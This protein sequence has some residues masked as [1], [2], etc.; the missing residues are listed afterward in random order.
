MAESEE[1]NT[2]S[3]TASAKIGVYRHWMVTLRDIQWEL[4]ALEYD[5]EYQRYE[6]DVTRRLHDA[7]EDEKE[8]KHWQKQIARISKAMANTEAELAK[9]Q[10]QAAY[11]EAMLAL[12]RGDLEAEGIDPEA[13]DSDEYDFTDEF[14]DEFDEDDI[15]F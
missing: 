11:C 13:C 12:I 4:E 8:R 1:R 15:P 14:D 9:V 10:K 3:K 2:M 6:M 5:R 7:T